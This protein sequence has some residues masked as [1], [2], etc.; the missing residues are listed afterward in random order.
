MRIIPSFWH[1][2]LAEWCLSNGEASA[3]YAVL[4][5]Y[6][7]VFVADDRKKRF[8][9]RWGQMEFLCS[10]ERSPFA[11]FRQRFFAGTKI[12]QKGTGRY[13]RRCIQ[14]PDAS[15]ENIYWTERGIDEEP[16]VELG[17]I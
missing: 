9:F 14:E 4:R 15:R 10:L 16:D 2:P 17:A 5:S 13:D 11:R 12:K 8:G 1:R 3:P 6:G 7:T